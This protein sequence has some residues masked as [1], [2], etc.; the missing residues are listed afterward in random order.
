MNQKDKITI[1]YKEIRNQPPWHQPTTPN[2]LHHR[3]LPHATYAPWISDQA[4]EDIYQKI[5]PSTLVDIYR[6]YE[7]WQ[8]SKQ[9]LSVAGDILEVGVWRGGTG[10]LIAQAVNNSEKKVFLAD[11]FKGVVKA[12][13]NDPVYQGGEHAD[14]SLSLAKSLIETLNLRNTFFLQGIFPEETSE[15]IPGKLA[16]VHC[17]VDVYSSARDIF[18]WA[19]PRLSSAGIIIFD[20]YGFST[21]EGVTTLVNEIREDNDFTFVHNLNGHAILIKK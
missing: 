18:Y 10:A 2:I 5:E 11:T 14:T 16:L 1:A 19:K 17:D 20:D 12:G 3:V 8:L 21:C 4:F 9:S 6:C 15:N 7:L 13:E